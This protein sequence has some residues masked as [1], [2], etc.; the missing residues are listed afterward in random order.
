[1]S[2]RSVLEKEGELEVA[3]EFE[4]QHVTF[5][6][7]GQSYG[8]HIG[9]VVEVIRMVAIAE[10]PET[11]PY[12]VG[13]VNIRGQVVPV[14]D[15]RRRLNLEAAKYDLETPILIARVKGITV[16]LVVDRVSEVVSLAQD[17]IEPA[18]GA[19]TTSRFVCGVAKVEAKLIFILDLAGLFSADESTAIQ[20]LAETQAPREAMVAG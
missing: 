3:A 8:L 19:F 16:G 13:V 20:R 18:A 7:A 2:D 5:E 9:Q 12:V 11:A 4:A 15:M 14:V 17:T 6:L 1:M 10:S